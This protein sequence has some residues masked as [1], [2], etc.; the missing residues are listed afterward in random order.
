MCSVFALIFVLLGKADLIFHLFFF[1]GQTFC[2][3]AIA[4][5]TIRKIQLPAALDIKV[6][7]FSYECPWGKTDPLYCFF[8][9]FTAHEHWGTSAAAQE[10]HHERVG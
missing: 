9:C 2:L 1:F 4:T 10:D 7:L 6:S 8:N 3:V 5:E